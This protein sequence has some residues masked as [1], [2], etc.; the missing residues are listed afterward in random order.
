MVALLFILLLFAPALFG[1]SCV[2]SLSVCDEVHI[3]DAVFIGTVESIAD[4]KTLLGS[5][6][7]QDELQ[8][9][10]AKYLFGETRVTLKVKTIFRQGSD[11]A[12]ADADDKDDHDKKL[13]QGESAVIWTESG[14]CGYE[15]QVG[16]TYLVYAVED[17]GSGRLE[18][19]RCTRTAR[20]TDAGEDLAYLYFY[21]NGGSESARL[22]GFAT[23]DLKQANRDR[24]HY[25]P[26]IGSP[27]SGITVEFRSDHATHF[28][29]PDR[30][31]RFLFDGLPEGIYRIFAYRDYPEDRTPLTS[32]IPLKINTRS[33]NSTVLFIPRTSIK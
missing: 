19:T 29:T 5:A 16:E 2:S 24:F 18:T 10:L 21:Q 17:E 14:D 23:S 26:Q 4:P 13:K 31:G 3:S 20:I 15:F 8:A 7:T 30:N 1:C 11:D 28:T 22:E 32:S 12:K 9:L 33:C 25:S 27:V 6:H